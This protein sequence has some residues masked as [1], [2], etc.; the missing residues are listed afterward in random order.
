[1]IER[2]ECRYDAVIISLA[3]RIRTDKTTKRSNIERKARRYGRYLG[4]YP[5]PETNMDGIEESGKVKKMMECL[6]SQ[7]KKIIR[8]VSRTG[9]ER[10]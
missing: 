1:M 9:G 2:L 10:L 5:L 6:A 4:L 7:G 8:K 3:G